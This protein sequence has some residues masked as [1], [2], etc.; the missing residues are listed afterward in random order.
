M[1]LPPSVLSHSGSPKS[2]GGGG[3]VVHHTSCGQYVG[4]VTLFLT[5]L[6]L[7]EK[8]IENGHEGQLCSIGCLF[9]GWMLGAKL[10]FLLSFC[11]QGYSHLWVV[12]GLLSDNLWLPRFRDKFR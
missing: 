5:G 2:V 3:Q 10:G 9:W 6:T 7:D 1:S 8:S 11:D 12:F 4:V